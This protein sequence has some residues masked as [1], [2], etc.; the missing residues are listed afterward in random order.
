MSTRIAVIV[1]IVLIAAGVAALVYGGFTYT[2]ETH[3]ADLG[4]A[5][6]RLA[7]QETVTIPVWAGVG[8]IVVGTLVLVFGRRRR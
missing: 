4:F 7:E 3:E 2:E 5:E 6:I 8:A 1:G